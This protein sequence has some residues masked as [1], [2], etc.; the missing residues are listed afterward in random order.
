MSPMGFPIKYPISTSKHSDR[1]RESEADRRLGTTS[2]LVTLSFG[3]GDVDDE[4][5]KLRVSLREMSLREMSF[6]V[7]DEMRVNERER[8][9]DKR[10]KKNY[11]S[12]II[13]ITGRIK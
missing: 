7:R 3:G 9:T 10:M 6:R 5:P 13:L 2:R 1:W 11:A 8:D 4:R 12:E